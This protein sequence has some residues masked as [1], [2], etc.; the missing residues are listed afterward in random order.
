VSPAR[1]I[2]LAEETGLVVALGEWVLRETCRQV[3]RWRDAGDNPGPVA[4][5]VSARQLAL[6]D[7]STRVAAIFAE[8]G[9]EPGAVDLEITETAI[10]RDPEQAAAQLNELA[11][12]GVRIALDDFGVGYSSLGYLK[13]LPIAVLKMDRSFIQDVIDSMDAASLA[14]GIVRLAMALDID[15]VAEG[16]ET[17]EQ[18]EFLR[19]CGC[20]LVQGY[21]FSR[22]VP[23]AKLDDQFLGREAV[24]V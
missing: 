16:V 15:V 18:V 7:F 20:D 10:M 2:P 3:R 21:Y 17:A 22:P 6:P 5:N 24:V 12:M 11:A 1:F 8:E 19:A 14:R 9:V 4:V 23:P 13:L